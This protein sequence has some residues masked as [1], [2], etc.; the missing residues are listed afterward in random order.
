MRA[1]IRLPGCSQSV[2]HP[3][4][5][6][7]DPAFHV[8]LPDSD[9]TPAIST[10]HPICALIAALVCRQ[11]AAPPTGVCRR[12]CSVLPAIVPKAPIDKDGYPLITKNKVWRGPYRCITNAK[13]DRQ[14]PAPTANPHAS[15]GLHETDFRRGIAG[16]PDG[17]HH[18][19]SFL[20][21]ENVCHNN[22]TFVAIWAGA[23]LPTHVV[24]CWTKKDYGMHP[25]NGPQCPPP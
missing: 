25:P 4:H 11:F 6:P 9:N 19:R 18:Q 7:D 3:Y 22:F 1:C 23:H 5:T 8:M 16:A 15:E 20:L 17:G 24:F 12:H 10:Q 21:R 2:L 13:P 14:M